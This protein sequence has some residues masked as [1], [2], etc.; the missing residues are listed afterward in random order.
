FVFQPFAAW[1]VRE[2]E[3]AREAACDA[4]ALEATGEPA[5]V[6][7][8]L[9]LKLT[10][11]PPRCSDGPALGAT[12]GFDA[13]QV[14]LRLLREARLPVHPTIRA[15]FALLLAA[16]AFGMIPWRLAAN[17]ATP[18]SSH[19]DAGLALPAEAQSAA[20]TRQMREIG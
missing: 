10:Q 12:G 18:S 14:R 2:W 17:A 7:G 20:C 11:A 8:R 6:Y 13:L 4:A 5:A 19:P 1:A 3:T 9:L 15:A 16:V